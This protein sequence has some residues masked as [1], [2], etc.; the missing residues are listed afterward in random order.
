MPGFVVH[1]PIVHTPPWRFAIV[2]LLPIFAGREGAVAA[3]V[4]RRAARV[5]SLT[6]EVDRVALH[7]ERAEHDAEQR[8]R[9]SSTGPCS[10]CSSRYAMA[11]ELRVTRLNVLEVDADFLQRVRQPDAGFVHERARFCPCRG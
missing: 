8:S 5:R 3:A 10:M 6:V 2:D 9:S 7:T 11:F 1:E 4:H